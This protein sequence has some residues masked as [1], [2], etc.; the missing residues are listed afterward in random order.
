MDSVNLQQC[1]E[2]EL[3]NHTE[4]HAL[5]RTT[6]SAPVFKQ[7]D[8]FTTCSLRNTA[9]VYSNPGASPEIGSY[10]VTLKSIFTSRFWNS[11]EQQQYS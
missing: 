4:P 11:R 7:S 6:G 5:P 8:E 9:V 3:V 10:E 2:W 1:L